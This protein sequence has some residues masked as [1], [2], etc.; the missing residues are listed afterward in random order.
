[1]GRGGSGGGRRRWPIGCEGCDGCDGGLGY[2]CCWCPSSMFKMSSCLGLMY[3]SVFLAVEGLSSLP[4]MVAT[5]VSRE[6]WRCCSFR[7]A[8]TLPVGWLSLY[9]WYLHHPTANA[10]DQR[11][12]LPVAPI[13]YQCSFEAGVGLGVGAGVGVGVGA[14]VGSATGSGVGCGVGCGEGR[15]E[16][17]RVGSA[18]G[19]GLGCAVGEYTTRSGDAFESGG[20][21]WYVVSVA[22]IQ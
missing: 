11:M 8:S 15:G 13:T 7:S 4:F 6:R 14:A 19:T 9:W 3:V 16:G 22:D 20:G 12:R 10:T 1:M 21:R 5:V 2:A 18:V 17:S